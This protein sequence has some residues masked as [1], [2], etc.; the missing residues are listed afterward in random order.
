MKFKE[1]III[2]NE[3]LSRMSPFW[4]TDFGRMRP[5]F[6]CTVYFWIDQTL[7]LFLN[8]LFKYYDMHNSV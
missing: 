5:N 4:D 8:A 6:K 3:V 1:Q 7:Y 2:F